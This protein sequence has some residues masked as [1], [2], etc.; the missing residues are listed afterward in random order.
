MKYSD[1][2]HTPLKWFHLMQYVILPVMIL[3]T[4]YR[5]LGMTATLGGFHIPYVTEQLPALFRSIGISAFGLGC[6]F[7]PIVIYYCINVLILILCIYTWIGSFHFRHSVPMS[8]ISTLLI[9]FIETLCLFAMCFMNWDLASAVIKYY[10]SNA[11][12]STAVFTIAAGIICGVT[13][14]DFLCNVIYFHKRSGLFAEYYVQPNGGLQQASNTAPVQK[15]PASMKEQ[16]AAETPKKMKPVENTDTE[17]TSDIV[18]SEET[19][20]KED[21]KSEEAETS[22]EE[23]GT[24][25]AEDKAETLSEPEAKDGNVKKPVAEEKLK[26]CPNCGSKLSDADVTFCSKCGCKLK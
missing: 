24:V 25:I 8:W 13:L 14:I 10:A 3:E 7:W 20:L 16:T 18:K 5:L 22:A 9:V 15:Q 11:N 2:K 4:V 6:Y 17:N 21:K 1:R 26:F 23:N 19:E 12:A